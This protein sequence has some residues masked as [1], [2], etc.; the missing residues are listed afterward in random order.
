MLSYESVKYIVQKSVCFMFPLYFFVV[1]GYFFFLVY[2]HT[3]MTSIVYIIKHKIV[4]HF[5]WYINKKLI[6]T[7]LPTEGVLEVPGWKS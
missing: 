7:V 6:R 5:W 4:Y 3:H 1:V 2:T